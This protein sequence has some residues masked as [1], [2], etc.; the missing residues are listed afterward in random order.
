M[1][2]TTLALP[3]SAG[4]MTIVSSFLKFFKD[5][6]SAG[7]RFEGVDLDFTMRPAIVVLASCAMEEPDFLRPPS[8]AA[9]ISG[10]GILWPLKQT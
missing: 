3:L 4:A 10:K 6:C 9:V 1:S 8:T 5:L 7:G 2:I